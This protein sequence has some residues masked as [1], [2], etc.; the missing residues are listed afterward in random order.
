MEPFLVISKGRMVKVKENGKNTANLSNFVD[1]GC[2]V[3]L[4]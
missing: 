2:T 4:P 1:Q 3:V